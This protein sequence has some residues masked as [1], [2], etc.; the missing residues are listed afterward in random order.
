[1]FLADGDQD[2]CDLYRLYFSRSGWRVETS[3]DG[4]EC[5][6]QLRQS[7]PQVL[8]LD[9][10]LLWGGADGLLSVMRDNA[11][12]AEIP[13]ILTSTDTL[14]DAYSSL[15]SPPVVQAL[16]KPFSLTVLLEAARA[17]LLKE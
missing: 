3:G 17:Q 4:I 8:I 12:L 6:A 7:T 5:L 10:Q 14:P 2:L 11:A 9:L 13:V 15:T 16:G 1:V